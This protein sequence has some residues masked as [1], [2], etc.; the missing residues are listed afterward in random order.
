MIKF[1]YSDSNRVGSTSSMAI[2]LRLG[3]VSLVLGSSNRTG[4][5]KGVD[6]CYHGSSTRKGRV[7]Q[8]T[9]Y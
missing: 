6:R 4:P 1:G 5:V 9:N 8:R 2:A 7:L 3:L